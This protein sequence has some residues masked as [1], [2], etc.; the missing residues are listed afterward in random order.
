MTFWQGLIGPTNWYPLWSLAEERQSCVKEQFCKQAA[1]CMNSVPSS[2][3]FSF[4]MWLAS[5]E[6]EKCFEPVGK[7]KGVVLYSVS[8]LPVR[9]VFWRGNTVDQRLILS[10]I[11]VCCWNFSCY[12]SVFHSAHKSLYWAVLM[13]RQMWNLGSISKIQLVSV[14]THLY[15][16]KSCCKPFLKINSCLWSFVPRCSTSSCCWK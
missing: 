13:L 11:Y 10:L 9:Y 14:L 2:V 15:M 3:Q 8:D 16:G 6:S 7:K 5:I 4:I 1:Y 12:C